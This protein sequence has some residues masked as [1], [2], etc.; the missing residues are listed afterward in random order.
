MTC[1]TCGRDEAWHQEN[2]PRHPFDPEGEVGLKQPSKKQQE[3][4]KVQV[5][6]GMGTD[7]I[8]RA[9][10]IRKGLITVE[11]L[12]ETEHMLLGNNGAITI[13]KAEGVD[14]PSGLR[15]GV[16]GADQDFGLGKA[17]K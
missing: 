8:L 5:I 3:Q 17:A 12:L 10:L 16:G 6:K 11:D 14:E 13:F 4:D 2:K 15:D 9:T 7:P 1:K